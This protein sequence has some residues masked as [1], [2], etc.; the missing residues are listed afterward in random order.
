VTHRVRTRKPRR[1]RATG[2]RGILPAP[3]RAD[4]PTRSTAGSS[5][6]GR[7]AL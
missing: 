3:P 7:M 6:C 5:G 2:H 1:R 4:A